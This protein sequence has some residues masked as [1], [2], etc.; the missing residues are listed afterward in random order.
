MLSLDP[1]SSRMDYY[2]SLLLDVRAL[3]SSHSTAF[4]L[5][6]APTF[7][8]RSAKTGSTLSSSASL[9]PKVLVFDDDDDDN[10]S[11]NLSSSLAPNSQVPVRP[12]LKSPNTNA[13][14]A[15]AHRSVRLVR[16]PC[17]Y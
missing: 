13:V 5:P 12:S 1:V 6:R 10:Y 7:P 3:Y 15:P 8:A 14:L 2:R 9:S 11:S 4:L 17:D 16:A